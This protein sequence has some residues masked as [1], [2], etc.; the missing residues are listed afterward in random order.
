MKF[1]TIFLLSTALMA[2]ARP[3]GQLRPAANKSLA[4]L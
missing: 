3:P 4:L 2:Q 1:G